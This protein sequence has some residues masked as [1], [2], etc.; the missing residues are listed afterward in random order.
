MLTCI[1]IILYEQKFSIC[2][3]GI[4][5]NEQISKNNSSFNGFTNS[6]LKIRRNESGFRLATSR[7]GPTPATSCS[8]SVFLENMT[9]CS[10]IFILASALL[11]DESLRVYPRVFSFFYIWYPLYAARQCQ[12]RRKSAAE[13]EPIHHDREM[14]PDLSILHNM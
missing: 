4:D 3:N 9:S 12:D 10:R 7:T 11:F 13:Q 5:W 2:W 1:L 14:L 6:D 8:S